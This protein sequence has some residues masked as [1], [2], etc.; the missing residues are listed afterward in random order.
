ML[1]MAL[2]ACGSPS[3]GTSEAQG[4]GGSA[5]QAGSSQI[6]TPFVECESMEDALEVAGFVMDG[7]EDVNGFSF[8]HILA[9]PEEPGLIEM[10]YTKGDAEISLRKAPAST[11]I[12]EDISGVYEEYPDSFDVTGTTAAGET[13]LSC[14]GDEDEGIVY[15][16]TW[17]SD[18]Y[19]YSLYA[20]EGLNVDDAIEV[21]QRVM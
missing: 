14:R 21:A 2:T 5:E 8:T 15:V 17:S 19:V 16:M 9:W 3:N 4:Q 10:G 18:E 1:V 12:G 11:P 20:S 6:A 7:P 13:T